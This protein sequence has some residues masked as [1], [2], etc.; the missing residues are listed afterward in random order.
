[1]TISGCYPKTAICLC[2]LPDA[3]DT[4]ENALSY[5]KECEDLEIVYFGSETKIPR[6]QLLKDAEVIA[7]A[8]AEH[9]YKPWVC[10]SG[11]LDYLTPVFERAGVTVA[12]WMLDAAI[13]ERWRTQIKKDEAA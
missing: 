1:M 10:F 8:L 6:E 2:T 5:I 12:H 11:E 7:K 13:F 4:V 3:L 9:K